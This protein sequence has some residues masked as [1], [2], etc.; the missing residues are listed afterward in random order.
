LCE[1]AR[2]DRFTAQWFSPRL[3]VEEIVMSQPP[4]VNPAQVYEDYFVPAMFSPWARL[5]TTRADPRTGQ[6]AIDVACGTGI[7]ARQLAPLVGE[8]GRVVAVDLNPAM[9]AVARAVPA[10]PGATIQWTQGDAG[11][12]AFGDAEFDLAFCQHGLTFFP[13]RVGALREMRRVLLPGGHAWIMVL[14]TLDQHP[15]FEALMTS[16]AG[17]LGLPL[18][19]VATPFALGDVDDFQALLVQAGFGVVDVRTEMTT[20]RFS[21]ALRFVPLAVASSAAAVPAFLRLQ[22][23]ERA[24]LIDK[25]RDDVKSTV[26]KRVQGDVVTFPMYAHLAV[27]SR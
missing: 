19:D 25:V 21:D 16:V 26:Q 20:V 2:L 22:A 7:V 24:A 18:F 15:V 23:P 3:R 11:A 27:V 9:L 5:L 6:C 10:P 4:L 1:L 12:L 8:T 13:D 14:Q 17:H